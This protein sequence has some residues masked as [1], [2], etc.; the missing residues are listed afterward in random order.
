MDKASKITRRFALDG[1]CRT[2]PPVSSRRPPPLDSSVTIR[3]AFVSFYQASHNER[4]TPFPP[5]LG[6]SKKLII[7]LFGNLHSWPFLQ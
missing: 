6:L 7:A 4:T 3:T 5:I 1:I 2:L